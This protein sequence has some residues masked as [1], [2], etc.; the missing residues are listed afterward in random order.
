MG[1]ASTGLSEEEIQRHLMKRT[2]L[3]SANQFNLN[4]APP[5]KQSRISVNK[6]DLNEACSDSD[7]EPDICVICQVCKNDSLCYYEYGKQMCQVPWSILFV[8][9]VS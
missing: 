2:H 3:S 1:R 5:S 9:S 8:V 4:E 6:L 7:E